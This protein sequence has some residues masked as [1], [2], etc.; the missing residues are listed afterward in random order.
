V[1]ERFIPK[2]TPDTQ[3]YWDK[4]KEGELWIPKCG[5]CG[6]VFFHPR[7][8]CPKC[9]SND[10]SWI[11]ASG[12]GKVESFVINHTPAA[13]YEDEVPYAIAFVKLEEGPRL[14]SNILGV[15][16]NPEAIFIGLDVEVTFEQRGDISL[17]QFRA[18]PAGSA[19]VNAV[20]A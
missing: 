7:S 15:A 12:R 3:M 4:A 16:Q 11:Q 10:V 13:G 20:S 17:P 1:A 19:V 2:P 8:L 18:V 5:A 9:G 6:H 14:T